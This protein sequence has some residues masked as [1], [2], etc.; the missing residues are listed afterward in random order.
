MQFTLSVDAATD[1]ATEVV[2]G[3]G[4]RIFWIFELSLRGLVADALLLLL[5]LF[6]VLFNLSCS[7][8]MLL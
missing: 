1:V 2:A 5:L 7:F 4:T 8:C 3:G 6:A